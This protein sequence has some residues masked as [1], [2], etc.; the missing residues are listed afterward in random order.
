[1]TAV[2]TGAQNAPAGWRTA[3]E[4]MARTRLHV[5]E[6]TASHL[7]RERLSG[8]LESTTAR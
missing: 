2:E 6:A 1:M 4:L 8:L 7:D 5:P 3:S